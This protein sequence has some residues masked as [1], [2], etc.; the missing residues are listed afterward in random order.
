MRTHAVL[1][2]SFLFFQGSELGVIEDDVDTNTWEDLAELEDS[3]D[4]D[5]AIREKR[6][7]ERERR[8]A[9]H[10]RKK[11]EKEQRRGNTGTRVKIG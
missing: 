5:S 8:M 7:A 4:L 9:E 1:W 2:L 6:Q 3:A 10:Q 11:Q